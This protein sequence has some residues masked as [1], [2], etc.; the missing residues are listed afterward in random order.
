MVLV[1]EGSQRTRRP[2]IRCDQ[3][4]NNFDSYLIVVLITIRL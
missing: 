4:L 3:F 2:L 1:A